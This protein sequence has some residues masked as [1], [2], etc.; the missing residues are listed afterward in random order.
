MGVGV[1]ISGLHGLFTNTVMRQMYVVDQ[2]LRFHQDHILSKGRCY[3]GF[4][5]SNSL[6]RERHMS[7]VKE[8]N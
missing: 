3:S 8:Q 1:R 2:V 5:I 4:E 7:P 6:G